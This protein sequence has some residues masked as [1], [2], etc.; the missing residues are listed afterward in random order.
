MREKKSLIN[1][2][3]FIKIE[4]NRL[5]HFIRKKFNDMADIEA[6]DILQEVLVRLVEKID[7]GL[8]LDNIGGYIYRSLNNKIVDRFRTKKN[9]LSLDEKIGDGGSL[10]DL[11]TD[12]KYETLNEVNK[13]YLRDRIYSAIEK[14]SPGQ[15]QVF[16][17]TELEGISF[18]E[19]S[20]IW[21]ENVGTL[22]SRKHRAVG[23]LQKELSD[24]KE[25]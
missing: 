7:D 2:I 15:R 20:E 9:N 14:L 11:L 4:K 25:I 18:Q 19:L 3:D 1:L 8:S 17:A 13:N 23:F 5:L 24:L 10:N 22:L 12:F 16:V 21:D 6:E